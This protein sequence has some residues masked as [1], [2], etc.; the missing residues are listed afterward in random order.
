LKDIV[1]DLAMATRQH[2]LERRADLR[3]ELDFVLDHRNEAQRIRATSDNKL[4][5]RNK[6]A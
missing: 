6:T 1:A 3:K 4:P 2:N 5:A